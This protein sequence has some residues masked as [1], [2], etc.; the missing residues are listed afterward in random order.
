MPNCSTDILEKFKDKKAAIF[1]DDANLFYMQKRIGWEIDWQKTKEFFEG[2]LPNSLWFYY[3]GMPSCGKGL[4]E[5]EE[6]KGGLEKSGFC[7]RTKPLKKIYLD[8]QKTNFKHK[9]NFD[10]EVAFDIARNIDKV[11]AVIVMSGDSDFLEAKNFCLQKSKGFLF[12]CFE[13]RVAWEI[14][15][16]YHVFIEDIKDFVK[17]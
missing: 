5:N 4:F 14:R 2:Y 11:D 10:V 16:V 13:A 17:K 8:D 15:R 3:L 6:L 7:V 9:C 12:V 1:I